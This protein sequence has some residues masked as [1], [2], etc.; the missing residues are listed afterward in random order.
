MGEKLDAAPQSDERCVKLSDLSLVTNR[1]RLPASEQGNMSCVE[2]A[3]YNGRKV[4]IKT[5]KSDG[6]YDIK[7]FRA[8]IDALSSVQSHR[9]SFYLVELIAY[10]ESPLALILECCENGSLYSY[11]TNH[12]NLPWKKRMEFL[13]RIA[14]GLLA[15][16]K[17]E[18]ERNEAS[19]SKQSSSGVWFC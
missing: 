7:Q 17:F 16:H 9:F 11:I 19:T 4:I 8:E 6:P 15:L 12:P 1:V 10:C 3:T 18:W 14:S 5:L 2:T 13:M